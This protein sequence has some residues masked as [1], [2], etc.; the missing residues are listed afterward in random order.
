[1]RLFY[2][3]TL[4]SLLVFFQVNAQSRKEIQ[5][6]D[7]PGFHTLKCDFH[8]HTVFSDGNVW[9][10]I[11]VNEAWTQG[12]DAIAITDHIEYR[13]HSKDITA[14]HN[15]SYEIAKPYADKA[16]LILIRGTEITRKMPPGHLNAIFI[17]DANL[18][19]NYPEALLWAQEKH[20]TLLA[21]SDVHDPIETSYD[22]ATTHRPVTLVFATEHT[23]E[24]LK[25]ALVNQQ[26]AIY[27]E[28]R[29]VGETKF[30]A[31]I[32]Y[33]S[34]QVLNNPLRIENKV[35]KYIQLHN[36]SDVDYDL[37]RINSVDGFSYQKHVVLKAHQTTLIEIKGTSAEIK[38]RAKLKLI[39]EVTN[40]T[41]AP[42]ENLK[43]EIE[44]S[45]L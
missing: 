23:P 40:L 36:N 32:F 2:I 42:A 37:S 45:N 11:R 15:R 38:D 28:D 19:E 13:P 43:V 41:V 5:I 10:T 34:I 16:G 18:I 29:L 30:L 6:P 35:T 3:G 22:L 20:L 25:M 4:L 33:A 26:T 7:I 1:M 14:D 12:L 31:P 39:Y 21:N 27:Y 44:V 9:P 17:T 24:A 8:I